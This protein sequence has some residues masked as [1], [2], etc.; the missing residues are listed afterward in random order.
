ML[1]KPQL[2]YNVGETTVL[3][4]PHLLCSVGGEVVV[5]RSHSCTV[6]EKPLLMG[7]VGEATV[8]VLCWRNHSC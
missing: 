3:E 4:V 6:L 1:K 5:W 8:V 2:L 7:I